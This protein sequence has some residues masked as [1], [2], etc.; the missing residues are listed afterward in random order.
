MVRTHF[1]DKDP[2]NR[3]QIF[4]DR[5]GDAHRS[6]VTG[7]GDQRVVLLAEDRTHDILGCCLSIGAGD[8][9]ADQIVMFPEDAFGIP[10]KAFIDLL[11][12]RRCDPG[13]RIDQQPWSEIR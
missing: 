7:R 1:T 11:F 4:P 5:A 6:I 10:D 12:Q 13:H 2:M 3:F 8:A 9:D